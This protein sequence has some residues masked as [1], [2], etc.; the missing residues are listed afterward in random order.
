MD[1]AGMLSIHRMRVK[2]M[3]WKESSEK[4]MMAEEEEDRE[5]KNGQWARVTLLRG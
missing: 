2:N 5:K 3:E 4:G 1:E